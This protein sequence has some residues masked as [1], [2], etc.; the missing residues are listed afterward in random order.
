MEAEAGLRECVAVA[1]GVSLGSVP[2]PISWVHTAASNIPA[3][4][5]AVFMVGYAASLI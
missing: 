5:I 1:T 4:F 2:Q 3:I